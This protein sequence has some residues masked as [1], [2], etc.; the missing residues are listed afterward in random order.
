[1][2]VII[3]MVGSLGFPIA[4]CIIL[5][6]Y[7]KDI[8]EKHKQESTDFAEALNRNTIVLQKLCD[9]LNVIREDEDA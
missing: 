4:V 9:K 2:D 8:T 7:I 1:M 3:Q 6:W 5:M